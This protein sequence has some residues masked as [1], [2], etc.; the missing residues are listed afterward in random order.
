MTH[1][2]FVAWTGKRTETQAPAPFV[3]H[4]RISTLKCLAA[5]WAA[6]IILFSR[7]EATA[8][9]NRATAYAFRRTLA[10]ARAGRRRAAARRRSALSGRR[11]VHHAGHRHADMPCRPGRWEQMGR[12]AWRRDEIQNISGVLKGC[13]GIG[14]SYRKSRSFTGRHQHIA[15]CYHQGTPTFIQTPCLRGC[16]PPQAAWHPTGL[17]PHPNAFVLPPPVCLAR[18][19]SGR[20]IFVLPRS[21]CEQVWRGNREP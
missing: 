12:R 19:K 8:P 20:R 16:A 21:S 13:G 15:M 4:E 9:Q 2:G 1:S 14:Q 18:Y 5:A 11:Q 3:R 17:G 7:K 6:A 10:R